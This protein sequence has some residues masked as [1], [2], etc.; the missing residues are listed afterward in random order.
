M[1]FRSLR[2]KVER[3]LARH[4]AAKHVR[5]RN[6]SPVVSFTFDDVPQSACREGRDILE[7]HA[8]RGTYY[9]CGG[10][11][12]ATT[13]GGKMHS[14]GDLSS[15]LDRGHELG[16]HGYGHLDYQT[17]SAGEIRADISRNRSFFQ[18]LG[19]DAS[20]L[21]F[22]YPY[23]CVSPAVKRLIGRGFNSARGIRPEL[24]VVRADLA[25]LNSPPLYQHL[26]EEHSLAQMIERNARENGWLI[27]FTHGVLERP[28]QF[29]CTP[30]MLDFAV[31]KALQSGARVAPVKQA[32]EEIAFRA[33]P[34]SRVHGKEKC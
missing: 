3:R 16:C 24:N 2:H 11:T 28:D 31:Q 13:A 25:L 30:S 19:C 5:M 23:G 27:F 9:V 33:A 21:N 12:D 7:R 15:L 29:D 32:L 8:C 26:W 18:E 4:L 6:R 20:G 10:F 34:E 17:L 14:R 1:D 22:A